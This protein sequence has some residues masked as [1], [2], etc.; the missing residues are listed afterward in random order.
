M[1]RATWD[2]SN[3]LRKV[4][5][6]R[7]LPVKDTHCAGLIRRTRLAHPCANEA[8]SVQLP[9]RWVWFDQASFAANSSAVML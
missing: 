6:G 1:V 2:F 7:L 3:T 4:A 9:H 8:P 5:I